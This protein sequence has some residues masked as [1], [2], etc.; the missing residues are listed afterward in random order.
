M[1]AR[2]GVLALAGALYML[3]GCGDRARAERTDEAP[4]AEATPIVWGDAVEIAAG[5]AHRGP[6]RMNASDFR[7]VD[8]PAVAAGPGGHVAVVWVDQARKDV[9]FQL[10]ERD[11]TRR[12]ESPANV[13]RSPRVFSW[14]PRVVVA[15][16]DAAE[17]NVLWQEIVFSGGSHGGEIFFARSRD[18][19]RSFSEPV[20]LSRT[21]AG[22]GK[23]RLSPERWDNGSLT[24]A[25][26]D[27]G[28]LFAAWTEYE[29]RLWFSRS[30]DG[31]ASFSAPLHVAGGPAAPV[32]APALAV[33]EAGTLHLAWSVGEDAAGDIQLATSTDG[34]ATFGPPRAVHPGGAHDDAPKLAVDAQGTLHLAYGRARAGLFGPRRVTYTR[35]HDGGSTFTPPIELPMPDGRLESAAFPHLAVQPDGTV[36]LL[37]ELFPRAGGRPQGLALSSS[38]DGGAT[39][40]APVQVP[41]VTGSAL[42]PNGSQQGLLMEKLAAL[43][44]G[45]F[46]LVNS[47]FLADRR[48]HVWLLTGR[49]DPGP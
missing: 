22:A 39:F 35:S 13:S 34:G 10:L 2:T 47:T 24:L 5:G 32:R 17:V 16:E 48:S 6:W 3:A 12:L 37:W 1:E 45:A 42:G 33:A 25:R 23:G 14:L 8:D 46:V 21:P 19:G 38:V 36:H 20:N 31:G 4:P 9:L 26:D 41:H 7:F 30:T 40:G 18:G 29:G 15:G 43:G 49:L 11:G 28:H 44:D 27:R